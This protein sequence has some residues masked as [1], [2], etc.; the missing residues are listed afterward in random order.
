MERFC[1]AVRMDSRAE[2]GLRLGFRF[3][4]V[5]LAGSRSGELPEALCCELV[6]RLG[7]DGLDFVV[8][9]APGVD[10]S[11][12]LALAREGLAA[13]SFVA[14][15]SRERLRCAYGLPAAVVV[16][17]ALSMAAALHRRTVWMVRRSSVVVL[18]PEGRD[19]S[20][21]PGSRLVLRTALEQGKPVFVASGTEPRVPAPAAIL[22]GSLYGLVRGWWVVP[23]AVH[24]DTL[25]DVEA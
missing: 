1:S 17:E 22:P 20:W 24:A 3:L 5:L 19:G 10:R 13:R 15:A 6:W 4:E 2:A 11:F 8:G 18:F 12:R 7:D 25:C 23:H 14:C 21:G 9:C 16:P